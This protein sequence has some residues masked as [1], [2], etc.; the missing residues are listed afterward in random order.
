[1]GGEECKYG[2]IMSDEFEVLSPS[3]VLSS[4]FAGSR[5]EEHS[6]KYS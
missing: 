5:I 2:L 1:M 3:H 4:E 6:A